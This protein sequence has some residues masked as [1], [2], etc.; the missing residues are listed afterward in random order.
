MLGGSL[1]LVVTL[2]AFIAGAPPLSARG[3]DPPIGAPPPGL[4]A[5]PPAPDERPTDQVIVRFADDGSPDTAAL[6]DGTGGSVRPVRQMTDGAWVVKL[7]ER[8]PQRAVEALADRWASRNDIVSA[9]PDAI[10]VPT[11]TPNDTYF[12]DQWHYGP[13]VSGSYGADLL[14]A[15]D[16]TT[17]SSD[18]VVAVLDT[19]QLDHVDL[20]G[21]FLP[22]YDFINDSLVANDG[23]GRDPNPAD[24]GDW[25]TSIESKKGFFKDCRV[26]D[27]SWH[28][29]HVAGTIG[30]STNNG[31]G[32]A[33]VNRTSKI[34]HARVLGKCGG[35]IS[36]LADAIRWTAGLPV[37]GIPTN[38]TPATVVNMSL[39]G[40][41][42][43]GTTY[44]SAI[45]AATEAGSVVVVSAGNSNVDASNTRPA[46]C[47]GVIAVAASQKDGS[48]A[49][50]SNYGSIVEITAP[51]GGTGGGVL[52]TLN[53]G[54]TSPG[55]DTYAWYQGTSMA[56]PHVS[57]VVSLM[58]SVAPDLTNDEVLAMLQ[59]SVTAF[60][61]GSTCTSAICGPGILSG[62]GAVAA[63]AATVATVAPP[64]GLLGGTVTGA[65][66]GLPLAGRTVQLYDDGV[67]STS[68]TTDSSGRYEFAGLP[69][70]S[71]YKLRFLGTA[72]Y[73]GQFNGGASN[74]F[75]A[76]PLTV[77]ADMATT[78]DAALVRKDSVGNMEGIVT[79]IVTGAPIPNVNVVL[80]HDGV[81]ARSAKTSA[82]GTWKITG[83]DLTGTWNVRFNDPSGSYRLQWWQNRPTLA[84]ATPVELTGGTTTTVDTSLTTF[85][86]LA[87]V[88]GTV[89][90]S[91]TG[92]PL[93]G[94]EVRAFVGDWSVAV[95]TT[96]ASGTYQIN[97]LIPGT[98]TLRFRD[99]A[100]MWKLRWWE[101][102]TKVTATP[103]VLPAAGTGSAHM[104][105]LPA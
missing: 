91:A 87:K 33:G 39:G 20:T 61:S 52:S 5:P 45:T 37:S 31:I 57:G 47:A 81:Q 66:T 27:S 22:G 11:A 56:A 59:S 73:L 13:P 76:S 70:G 95:A 77:D 14:G 18:V 19:G 9:E 67:L 98:Y 25:I 75:S 21:R 74:L 36:D 80:F 55:V 16:I 4:G 83:L 88:S 17:G 42:E 49:T 64:T 15:W 104:V 100:G 93:Q 79:D 1:V 51:G 2:A 7:P 29:T 92:L 35:Y 10:M 38:P 60:P 68:T 86:E 71:A 105:L 32:V 43:C 50:Y 62:A 3:T 24:P 102:G 12:A 41:G 63:A 40:A 53:T 28:G 84:S 101:N 6:T 26:S 96:N 90:A 72:V 54:T 48:R 34:L 85:A 94:I 8:A 23:D 82:T 30:A 44:Q 58:R 89:T 78:V 103:L 99:P 97:G 46:N 69:I 65:D